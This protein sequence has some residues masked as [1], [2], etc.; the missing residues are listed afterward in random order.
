MQ[1]RANSIRETYRDLLIRFHESADEKLLGVAQSVIDPVADTIADTF[2]AELLSHKGTEHLLNHEIVSRHLRFSMAAWLRDMFRPRGPAD[3]AA[4]IQRQLDVGTVHARINV[5]AHLV[6]FGT[7][8]LKREIFRRLL[9]APID[10]EDA[11]NLVILVDEMMDTA[12]SLMQE[13]YVSDLVTNERRAQ[14]L[15]MNAVSS[16]LAIECERLRS[17]LL[18]WLR[19][20]LTTL[21]QSPSPL[22]AQNLS[23]RQS[24][25]GL[26]LT[27]KADLLLQEGIE[28]RNLKGQMERIEVAMLRAVAARP[29][30]L[31]GDFNDAV[32]DLNDAVTQANWLLSSLIE[33]TLEMEAG[34]DPLTKLFNRRYL[35]TIIQRET[36]LSN[37]HGIAY[38]L[39]L[40]DLDSFAPLNDR[41][42]QDKGDAALCQAAELIS[43]TVRAGDFVFRYGGDEFL[44]L[45]SDVN[46]E[47]ALRIAE[48][49]R[50]RI[51]AH[52]FRLSGGEG[53]HLNA[54]IGIAV[55]DGHPD[56]SR[57]ITRA[58]AALRK[59]KQGGKGRCVLAGVE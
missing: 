10:R 3:L 34:R 43:N 53:I 51:A 6:S 21:Y 18:D 49:L 16:N 28:V 35:P 54:S 24:D 48:E 32:L 37:R 57:M 27:H 31:S 19:K 25:F 8:I 56:Y 2:Y 20:V 30:G 22:A 59:A 15:K 42:G 46:A 39:L 9:A 1:E 17:G 58:D 47:Q 23:V 36:E 41:F 44:V 38:G 40:I 55:H 4:H 50:Q 14:S 12:G 26:W 33:R 13:S 7:R 11:A 45:L 52:S 5:P 29:K